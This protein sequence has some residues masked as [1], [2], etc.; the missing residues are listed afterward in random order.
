MKPKSVVLE[1]N[2][3]EKAALESALER[4]IEYCR[5]CLGTPGNEHQLVFIET[6][7]KLSLGLLARLRK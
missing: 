1:L 7:L 6:D 5:G 3:L 2:L 4:Y